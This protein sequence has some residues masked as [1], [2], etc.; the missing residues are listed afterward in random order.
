MIIRNDGSGGA[1]DTAIADRRDNEGVVRS[2]ITPELLENMRSGNQWAF[3]KIYLHYAMPVNGFLKTLMRSEEL[4]EEMTQQVFVALWENREK[5]DP[6]NNISGYIYTIARNIAFKHF[7]RQKDKY[8]GDIASA[9]AGSDN[10]TPHEELIYKEIELLI[11][12][13]IGMM[14]PQRREIFLMSRKSGMTNCEIA[15]KLQ[16]SKNTVENQITTALKYLKNIVSSF[17]SILLA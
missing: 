6:H 4:S 1:A 12:I 16:I 9:E 17:K 2:A 14:P 13:A 5:I 8:S 7:R 10:I 3:E 11:D 15:S